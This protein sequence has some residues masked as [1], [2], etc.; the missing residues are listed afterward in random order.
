ML[1]PANEGGSLVRHAVQAVRSHIRENDLKVGDALPGESHFAGTLGVSRA[2]MREAFGALAALRQID[3][4][5]GR[6]ARVAAIDGSVMA[7]SLDHAVATAQISFA[8]VWDVR[9]TVELRI[10]ELAALRRT[11]AQARNIVSLADAMAD[12]A[13]D[14]P[15]LTAIDISLHQAIAEASHNALFNQMV[16]SYAALMEVAVPQAWDTR[17][18]EEERISTLERHRAMARS[19]ADGDPVA[20]VAAMEAHFDASIQGLIQPDYSL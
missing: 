4:A 12:S 9:R 20:A 6:R 3:V 8:E 16:R 19:I 18:S 11:P 13:D 14:L 1:N 17:T 7:A 10:A 2:V 5:N 15:R